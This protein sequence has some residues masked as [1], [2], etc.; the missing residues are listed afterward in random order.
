[1]LCSPREIAS[2]TRKHS[3]SWIYVEESAAQTRTTHDAQWF[4]MIV[5]LREGYNFSHFLLF[6]VLFL[7]VLRIIESFEE[8]IGEFT[9][10]SKSLCLYGI[11]TSLN[12][13]QGVRTMLSARRCFKYEVT[14][15]LIKCVG[16]KKIRWYRFLPWMK[17]LQLLLNRDQ[18]WISK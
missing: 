13:I 15:L 9:E 18:F 12:D 6:H 16:L 4:K 3:A 10:D 2:N 5:R 1:M 17:L 8:F 14:I 11:G 7:Y